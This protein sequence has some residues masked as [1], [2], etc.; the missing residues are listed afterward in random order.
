[1]RPVAGGEVGRRLGRP[2]C[3]V[4][5]CSAAQVRRVL[6]SAVLE[7]TTAD[8]VRTAHARGLSGAAVFLRHVLPNAL[9][10][11]VALLAIELQLLLGG[12]IVTE[13]V[14]AYPGLGR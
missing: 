8:F 7:V 2:A 5:W 9:I 3:T 14:F 1:R 11:V 13:T 12:A 10:S 4:G 6:R